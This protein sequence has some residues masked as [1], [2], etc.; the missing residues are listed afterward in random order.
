MAI[1]V[2]QA[3]Q[4]GHKKTARGEGG[5]WIEKGRGKWRRWTLVHVFIM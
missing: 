4:K 5:Y 1:P 2:L 3:P